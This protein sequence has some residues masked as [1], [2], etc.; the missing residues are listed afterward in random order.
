MPSDPPV[1]WTHGRPLWLSSR[2]LT[3]YM[4]LHDKSTYMD[5]IWA[6]VPSP[7]KMENYT[8]NFSVK[9]KLNKLCWTNYVQLLRKVPLCPA[10]SF[11]SVQNTPFDDRK[12]SS[13]VLWTMYLYNTRNNKLATRE[14]Q[15]RHPCPPPPPHTHT[16]RLPE[17]SHSRHGS[18]RGFA[19]RSV[20]RWASP[21]YYA[22]V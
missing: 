21:C 20:I 17:T 13:S 15:Q 5:S 19:P 4:R 3:I 22:T 16:I 6:H 14:Q 8:Y 9:D 7:S 10:R 1:H 12:R 18:E 11:R 2:P